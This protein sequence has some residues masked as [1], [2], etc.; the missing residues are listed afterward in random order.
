LDLRQ[1]T[2]AFRRA[3]GNYVNLGGLYSIPPWGTVPSFGLTR[4]QSNT[5]NLGTLYARSKF[6]Y[7][8][9]WAY[10]EDGSVFILPFAWLPHD[11]FE[12]RMKIAAH[13]VS[14]PTPK[15]QEIRRENPHRKRFIII[16]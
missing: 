13:F 7:P 6:K 10:F 2:M 4:P 12:A 16:K 11:A 15:M 5:V 3:Y 8:T 14:G 9:G 1:Q